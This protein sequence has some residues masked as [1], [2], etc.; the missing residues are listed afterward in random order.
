LHRVRS[1]VLER[2]KRAEWTRELLAQG[3]L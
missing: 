3:R 2:E 1:I